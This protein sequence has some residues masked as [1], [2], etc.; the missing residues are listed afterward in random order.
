M[1]D[2]LTVESVEDPP[3][4]P[5][6]TSVPSVCGVMTMSEESK[7]ELYARNQGLFDSTFEQIMIKLFVGFE[8]SKFEVLERN[9]H[10]TESEGHA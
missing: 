10:N 5:L 2:P 1:L 4:V 8:R 7:S 3:P 6:W 9:D